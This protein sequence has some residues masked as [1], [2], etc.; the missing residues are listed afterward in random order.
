[1]AATQVRQLMASLNREMGWPDDTEL[2]LVP[3][4]PVREKITLEE[5][6]CR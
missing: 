6:P 5:V 2:E 4:E 3:P 1:M